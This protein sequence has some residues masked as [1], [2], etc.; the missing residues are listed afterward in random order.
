MKP[1]VYDKTM[2]L[3]GILSRASE[4]GYCRK[5]NELYTASFKLPANDPDLSICKPMSYVEIFDGDESKGLYR[6]IS[7]PK[8]T[9]GSDA[10]FSEFTCEHVL[11]TLMNDVVYEKIVIEENTYTT[12][13]VIEQLLAL[14]TTERWVLG[15]CDFSFT[16]AYEF[17]DKNVLEALNEIPKSFDEEYHWTYDTSTYPWTLNL[18]EC[19]TETKCELRRRRNTQE[20]D[21]ECDSSGIFNRLYCTGKTEKSNNV[22]T[23]ESVNDGCPYI[24]DETSIE[25]YGLIAGQFTDGD[26]T[27]PQELLRK[28]RKKL[29]EVKNPKYT[30]S[31]K[32]IDLFRVSKA[33]WDKFDEGAFV[34]IIDTVY[35]VDAIAVIK[36]VQKDDVDGDPM[37]V[38]LTIS[39]SLDSASNDITSISSKLSS[40]S[41]RIQI[42]NGVIGDIK[43]DLVITG[44]DISILAAKTLALQGDIVDIQGKIVEIESN[45]FAIDSKIITLGGKVDQ[46]YD[47]LI[48]QG[49][50]ITEIKSDVF[51][52]GDKLTEAQQE[53]AKNGNSITALNTDVVSLSNDLVVVKT[54]VANNGSSITQINTDI[55]EIKATE[56]VLITGGT[57]TIEGTEYTIVN[58]MTVMSNGIQD[59]IDG[60]SFT[61]VDKNGE[62]KTKTLSGEI[63]VKQLIAGKANI[64][65]LD[66]AIARIETLETDALTADNISAR[67]LNVAGINATSHIGCYSITADSASLTHITGHSVTEFHVGQP[68][69]TVASDGTVTL[70]F[71]TIGSSY[72]ISFSTAASV[73]VGGSWSGSKYSVTKDGTEVTSTTVSATYGSWAS[74]S[75]PIYVFADGANRASSSVSMPATPDVDLSCS[76]ISLGTFAI[77]TQIGGKSY[78]RTQTNVSASYS[79]QYGQRSATLTASGWTNGTNKVTNDYNS[80]RYVNVSVPSIES[81]NA[82]TLSAT[83]IGTTVSKTVV[84]NLGDTTRSA[85]LSIDASAVYQAGYNAGKAAMGLSRTKNGN[86]YTITVEEQ[87]ASS[88][89]TSMVLT[90]SPSSYTQSTYTTSTHTHSIYTPST[91][92]YTA[93]SYTQEIVSEAGYLK[94]PSSYTKETHSYSASVYQEESYTASTYNKESYSSSSITW[95]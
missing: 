66:A 60:G 25:E 80:E 70:T 32:A 16:K 5:F 78:S 86:V 93:S 62:T 13:E 2:N 7:G 35:G 38:S 94:H 31:A 24:E 69:K 47:D 9:I 49:I 58:G 84:A 4:T 67:V 15:E 26:E 27:V 33:D 45:Y 79:V 76:E 91:H 34:H 53:I 12:E 85:S 52:V 37:Q 88:R 17:K 36:E 72:S 28:A 14:Q 42:N 73:V 8:T 41:K 61:Y 22:V 65:E 95:S 21:V 74:G 43:E 23:I 59:L 71:P 90:Y 6:I 29:K 30:Y 46:T 57:V 10:P 55:T 63:A 82:I 1:R 51:V 87:A 48:A 50:T 39:T 44:E 64:G 89:T 77:S 3:V 68:T 56:R 19:D 40:N 92:R 20:L 81:Y 54:D 18:V 75:I 83:D 11:G